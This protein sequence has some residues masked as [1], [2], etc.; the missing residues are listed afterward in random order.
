MEYRELLLEVGCE[1]MP[2]SWIPGLEAQ[3]AGRLAAAS[4]EPQPV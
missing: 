2:A 3:L 4:R 1:E